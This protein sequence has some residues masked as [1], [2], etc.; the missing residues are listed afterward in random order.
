MKR[1]VLAM[2]AVGL[3]LSG[4]ASTSPVRVAEAAPVTY[5]VGQGVLETSARPISRPKSAPVFELPEVSTPKPQLR[6]A[7]PVPVQPAPIP[8]PAQPE[9]VS[10][11]DGSILDDVDTELYAHQRVGRRYKVFGKSYTPKHQPDYDETGLASWYGPKFH[12]K[13]TASGETFDMHG[14]SAAHK[15]L[16]L[17]SLVH[18]ENLMTGK[19]LVLRVNDR[20]P[21]VKGRIIDLSKAAAVELGLLKD[22][23]KRVRVRY[24]GPA[25]PN[26]L[27]SPMPKAPRQVVQADEPTPVPAAQPEPKIETPSYR[28]LRRL[29]ERS[30]AAPKPLPMAPVVPMSRPVQPAPAPVFEALPEVR[31]EVEDGPLTLTIKGPI[32]LAKSSRIA[33]PER[34]IA[35]THD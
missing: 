10:N 22:G 35:A 5:K 34:I 32:H 8:A 33:H 26:D 13:L 15:T 7:K 17:N 23:L 1:V 16:P 6:A 11:D 12:G 14:M 27:D 19:T 4:C 31:P 20:G 25:D 30:A 3:A 9:I 2:A 28:P 18:V 21:F 29:P 24:A